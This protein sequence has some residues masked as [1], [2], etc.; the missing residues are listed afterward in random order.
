MCVSHSVYELVAILG[1]M[2]LIAFMWWA[3]MNAPP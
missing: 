3:W 2:C 1:A